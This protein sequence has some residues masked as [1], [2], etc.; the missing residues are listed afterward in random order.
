VGFVVAAYAVGALV[1]R[2]W[3]RRLRTAWASMLVGTLIIYGFGLLWLGLVTRTS[4][5]ETLVL[6]LYP[7]V[8]GDLLK[9]ALAA[10]LLPSAWSLVERTR[11]HGGS[12]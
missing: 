9:I 1:E 4:L 11:R 2:G 3:D 7:F 6:G 5:H 12:N 10:G 8:P